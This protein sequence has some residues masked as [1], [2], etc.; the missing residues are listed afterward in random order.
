MKFLIVV[1]L[2]CVVGVAI[3]GAVT[4]AVTRARQARSRSQLIASLGGIGAIVRSDRAANCFGIESLGKKQV[5]GTGTLVLTKRELAFEQLVPK[6]VLRVPIGQITSVDT[7]RAFLGKTRGGKILRVAWIT[8]D[9]GS[10]RAAWQVSDLDG[11]IRT[12]S[13][14]GSSPAPPTA[15]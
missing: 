3:I 8:Q 14:A 9:G 2:L 13:D 11:W 4:G 10:D 5:R 6:R 7:T 1:G 15:G 12:L